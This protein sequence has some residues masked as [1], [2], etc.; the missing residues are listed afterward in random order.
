MWSK[1]P[2]LA[3]LSVV[4]QLQSVPQIY[5]LVLKRPLFPA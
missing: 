1:V 3:T 4:R 5:Q 2:D